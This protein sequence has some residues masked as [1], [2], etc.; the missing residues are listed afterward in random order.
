MWLYALAVAG[1]SV[2]YVPFLTLLLPVRVALA[3]V[4]NDDADDEGKGVD[5][6]VGS[7]NG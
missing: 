1:G 2:S 4:G 6:L 3:P 5:R 7:I